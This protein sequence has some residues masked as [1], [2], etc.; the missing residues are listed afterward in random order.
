MAF[1]W[2][3]RPSN[4]SSDSSAEPETVVE[5]SSEPET[6]P[7]TVVES[8]PDTSELLAFAK[9]AYKNIQQKQQ[10]QTAEVPVTETTQ[11]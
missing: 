1:N 4:D 7:E 9:A 2:F 8:T 3:R 10:S 5:T 11:P 6:Q